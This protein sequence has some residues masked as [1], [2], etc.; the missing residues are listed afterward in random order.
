[1]KTKTFKNLDK[2]YNWEKIKEFT[3][4]IISKSG[5]IKPIK[6]DSDFNF[7]KLF[8]GINEYEIYEL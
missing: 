7:C 4:I 5:K 3:P 1:M 2:R 8:N 6:I